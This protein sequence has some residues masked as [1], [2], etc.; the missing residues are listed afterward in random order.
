MRSRLASLLGWWW[1]SDSWVRWWSSRAVLL[2]PWPR[3][4]CSN[5]RR[6]RAQG[7]TGPLGIVETSEHSGR[8]PALASGRNRQRLAKRSS[9]RPRS[10]EGRGRWAPG[11]CVG[12]KCQVPAVSWWRV[13][14]RWI[15]WWCLRHTSARLARSVGPPA[16]PSPRRKSGLGS[17]VFGATS[18]MPS[19]SV[20]VRTSMTTLERPRLSGSWLHTSAA[21]PPR[22]R[23]GQSGRPQNFA[24]PEKARREFHCQMTR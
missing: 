1:S 18:V 9:I 22:A 21:T 23:T 17:T 11:F 2:R 13:Q 16:R 8:W 20:T 14:P 4:C 15:I 7:S 19:N 5:T 3:E 12:S 6:R 24:R 10:G